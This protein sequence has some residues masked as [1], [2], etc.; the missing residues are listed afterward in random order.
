MLFTN[1]RILQKMSASSKQTR[2][3]KKKKQKNK[4]EETELFVM[5]NFE[6]ISMDTHERKI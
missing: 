3:I 4:N 6:N 5:K 1:D 2:L